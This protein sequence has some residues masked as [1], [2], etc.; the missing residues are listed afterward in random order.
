S[1]AL[2]LRMFRDDPNDP[3]PMITLADQKLYHEERPQAAMP[4]I[5]R[6]LEAARR[7][8]DFQRQA[9]GTK[10]RIALALERYDVVEGV[11]KDIMSLKIS[12]DCIDVGREVDF[13]RRVPP[14]SID[15][16]VA[17]QYDEYWR[18]AQPRTD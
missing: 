2:L 5:E 9:L 12:P 17:R 3:L 11:L 7:S 4:F 13:L 18:A 1:E 6:A 8:G 16:E 14:G 15:P 10:A